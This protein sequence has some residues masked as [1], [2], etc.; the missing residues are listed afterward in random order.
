TGAGTVPV[1][2]AA[3]QFFGTGS[4]TLAQ[5]ATGFNTNGSVTHTGIV[6]NPDV[7]KK[8]LEYLGNDPKNTSIST[9]HALNILPGL[10]SFV[11]MLVD[12]V[13]A[14]LTDVNGQRLGFSEV[15]GILAEIPNSAYYGDAAGVRSEERRVGKSVGRGSRG[16]VV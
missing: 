14:I 3:G 7:E 13:E 11:V 10:G 12:P 6:S 2:S 1:L 4:V 15:T 5:F 16:G 9:G 8:I